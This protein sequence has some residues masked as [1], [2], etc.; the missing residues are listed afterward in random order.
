M[1][2]RKGEG[3]EKAKSCFSRHHHCQHSHSVVSFLPAAKAAAAIVCSFRLSLSLSLSLSN[4]LSHSLLILNVQSVSVLLLLLLLLFILLVRPSDRRLHFYRA[5]L[6]NCF[7]SSLR[8]IALLTQFPCHSRSFARPSAS[9][10]RPQ[11]STAIRAPPPH[12]ALIQSA[13]TII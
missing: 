10:R 5:S 3:R 4:S 9:V 6:T 13:A 11:L 12:R 1:T 8:C 7:C 2:R